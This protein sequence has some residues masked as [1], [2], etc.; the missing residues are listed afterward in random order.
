[1]LNYLNWLCFCFKNYAQDPKI[2]Q[3]AACWY[4]NDRNDLNNALKILNKGLTLHKNNQELYT[5]AIKLE[6][7]ML[8]CN[9]I[10]EEDQN[11]QLKVCKKIET[12]VTFICDCINDT[13]YLI[14]ILNMLEQY[15]FTIGVQNL[16]IDRLLQSHSTKE[17]VWHTLAQRE[18]RGKVF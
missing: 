14:Q 18:K 16:I 6:L 12:Y 17:F 8:R 3:I 2:W 4:A 10:A 15:A 5:E 11:L 9:S 13:S 1:M 7:S